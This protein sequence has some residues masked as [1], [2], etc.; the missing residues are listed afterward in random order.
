MATTHRFNTAPAQTC[1]YRYSAKST[2]RP[3]CHHTG[4]AVRSG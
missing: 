3:A 2:A 1:F 4:R